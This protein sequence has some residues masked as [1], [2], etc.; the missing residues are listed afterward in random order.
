MIPIRA[1]RD[2]VER[3]QSQLW[4]ER[5]NWDSHWRDIADHFA[6]RRSRFQ[7]SDRTRSATRRN[8]KII[9]NTGTEAV[10]TLAAG[11]M[12]GLTSPSRPWFRLI[13]PDATLNEQGAVKAWLYDT[14]QRMREV[15]SQ[16]NLYNTLQTS[17]HELGAFGTACLILDED[18]ET[19]IRATALTIG[20]YA[21]ATSHRGTVDTLVRELSMTP[22][23]LVQRFGEKNVSRQTLTMAKEPG[24]SE[25]WVT[26]WHMI[27]P[28]P[29]H[30]PGLLSKERKPF[31][32]VYIE[33]GGDEDRVLSVGGYD[34]L[35]IM[36]PRWEVNAED[37]Y[38]GSPGMSGLGD[39]RA[40]Q[41]LE[42]RKLEIVDKLSDP[43]MV[44]SPE[45]ETRGSS[46]LPG[47]V[48]Y[49]SGAHGGAGFAPAYIPN[50][51]ALPALAAEIVQHERRINAAFYVDL[52]L[53]LS[54]SD[55]RQITAREVEERHEEKLLMLGPVVERLDDELLNLIIDRVFDV[56][57]R[58]QLIAEPPEVLQGLDLRPEYISILA[59]AQRAVAVGGIERMATFATALA[60]SNPDA[61]DKIDFDQSIDE[62]ARALGAPP[63]MVR[64]DEKVREIRDARAQQAQ[65]AQMAEQAAALQSMAGAAK[66]A[67][68]TELG[69]NSILDAIL[70][71]SG[72]VAVA[73]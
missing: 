25:S 33:K 67:S 4:A 27:A 41:M 39:C 65:A 48:T 2:R 37:V 1:I 29:D 32:S 55:R 62:Y 14:E 22:R 59:Q 12:A 58:R 61:L 8:D 21:I 28:N 49:V 35:P 23:Q 31:L 15:I 52:F 53:M 40:L 7:A 45:L 18:D 38:G 68:E 16:S 11:M 10:K 13:T 51:Q 73:A 66:D 36:A 20:T 34:S 57:W 47:G 5:S 64:T 9:N 19:V 26:V 50:P 17:Y 30:V 43:P 46:M 24:K 60:Q 44:G 70:S 42:R 6:P 72:G 69:G 3:T 56:M 54:Q 63:T 71:P